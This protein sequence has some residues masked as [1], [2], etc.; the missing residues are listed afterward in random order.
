MI[1]KVYGWFPSGW[2]E[3]DN[4]KTNAQTSKGPSASTRLGPLIPA[5][6]FVRTGET[7]PQR[8]DNSVAARGTLYLRP[9]RGL[10]DRQP[11]YCSDFATFAL[12]AHAVCLH[13]RAPLRALCDV[14]STGA[15]QRTSFLKYSCQHQIC[16]RRVSLMHLCFSWN[17]SE[18]AL[19]KRN[20]PGD[21]GGLINFCWFWN[22]HV[23]KSFISEHWASWRLQVGLLL[24]TTGT[25][26]LVFLFFFFFFL[27][28]TS[29][30]QLGTL[31]LY[32]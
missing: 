16:P 12:C 20:R 29:Y 9:R 18:R 17:I 2:P 32:R 4:K 24:F 15:A 26:P 19:T 25:D 31:R 1:A 21:F 14:A 10:R 7:Q 28:R 5:A 27:L 30:S 3:L 11:K 23:I 22:C 13:I 8:R 6:P